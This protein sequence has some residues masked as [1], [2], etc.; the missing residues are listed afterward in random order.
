MALPAPVFWEFPCLLCRQEGLRCTQTFGFLSLTFSSFISC[1]SSVRLQHPHP[2]GGY[3]CSCLFTPESSWLM[4]IGIYFFFCRYNTLPSRRTL[5][6]SRLVSKKDDVHVCIMCLR[7][8]MNY[9]VI[10]G[11]SREFHGCG[12]G[13]LHSKLEGNVEICIEVSVFWEG[14]RQNPGI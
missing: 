1:L 8:I 2:V 11:N 3:S 6:N 10:P 7:A 13:I 12:S 4:G 5:K 14:M 9:Q